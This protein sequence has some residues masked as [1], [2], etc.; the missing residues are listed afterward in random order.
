VLAAPAVPCARDGVRC[1]H[2]HTGTVGAFRHSLRNG[3]TAYA[4]LSPETNS[5]CLRRR[6]IDGVRAPGGATQRLRRL[7]AS[8]GRQDHTVLPYA[9][10]PLVC[11]AADRSQAKAHPAIAISAA[12]AAASTAFRPNVRDDRDTPLLAGRNGR[13]CKTDLGSARRSIFLRRGLDGANQVDWVEK[14]SANGNCLV[15][16]FVGFCRSMTI[17]RMGRAKRNPSPLL[18]GI[19][20]YRCR[21]RSLSYGG[22]VAPPILRAIGDCASWP[23]RQDPLQSTISN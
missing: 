4:V 5:F 20:G 14:I 17:R 18:N 1:A 9:S 12:G 23:S 2:E 15:G 22:Q 16:I 7:D 8:H 6:R 19:D 3:F 11:R 13:G 21:L 10:A